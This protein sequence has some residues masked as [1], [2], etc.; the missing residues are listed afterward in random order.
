MFDFVLKILEIIGIGTSEMFSAIMAFGILLIAGYMFLRKTSIEEV[1]S[2][3]A[4]HTQQIES[5]MQQVKLLSEELTLART[6]LKEI[7][8]QNIALMQQVRDSSKRIQELE[9]L[10]SKK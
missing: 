6:Q 5:L 10:L 1:T 8:D 2:A 4:L 3:G 9:D 7:H